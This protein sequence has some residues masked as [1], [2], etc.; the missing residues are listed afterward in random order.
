MLY[1]A[2]DK[3]IRT[4][5]E[6][7]SFRLLKKAAQSLYDSATKPSKFPPILY[8]AQDKPIIKKGGETIKFR[9]Y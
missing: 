3:P 7:L 8:D 4:K 6:E 1:D 5:S 2:N 9:R